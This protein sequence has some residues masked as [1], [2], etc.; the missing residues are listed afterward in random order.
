MGSVRDVR[1]TLIGPINWAG[2]AAHAEATLNTVQ[3]G[4]QAIADDVVEK[5]TKDRGPG[6]PCG[7]TKVKRT[8]VV[9]YDI[10]EWMQGVEEDAPE[11]EARN[12]NEIDLRSECV[13][14]EVVGGA[15]DK[16][17][18]SFLETCLVVHPLLVGGSSDWESN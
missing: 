4:G 3:E 15:E 11:V 17:D 8:H 1:F 2:R 5:R 6:C 10:K 16:G 13:L 12:G 7:M 9:A 18:H 14:V